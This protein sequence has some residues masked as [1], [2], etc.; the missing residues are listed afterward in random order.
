[1]SRER[2]AL[3]VPVT[4]R[5]FLE[6]DTADRIGLP[7]ELIGAVDPKDVKVALERFLA[8]DPNATGI[9]TFLDEN[10]SA[11]IYIADFE[12]L[13]EGKKTPIDDHLDGVIR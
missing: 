10:E 5:V 2:V 4:I 9:V 1:M 12:V 11:C 13:Q 8:F 3:D 7:A 6:G